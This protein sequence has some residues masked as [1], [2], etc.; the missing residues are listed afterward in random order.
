MSKRTKQQ[1]RLR[2]GFHSISFPSEWGAN[3]PDLLRQL[4]VDL[5]PFN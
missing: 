3:L 2:K 5:F 4:G 1:L